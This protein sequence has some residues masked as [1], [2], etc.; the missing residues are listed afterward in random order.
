MQV[1]DVLKM[2]PK[3]KRALLI[4]LTDADTRE[5]IAVIASLMTKKSA[6]E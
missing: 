1:I 2:I 3:E 4:E 5:D 6:A